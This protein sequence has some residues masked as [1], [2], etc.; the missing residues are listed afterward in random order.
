MK[1]GQ[2]PASSRIITTGGNSSSKLAILS[3]NFLKIFVENIQAITPRVTEFAALSPYMVVSNPSSST[4]D[5]SSTEQAVLFT[6]LG[7]FL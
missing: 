2:H 6:I 5:K 4:T 7:R 1:S 3:G